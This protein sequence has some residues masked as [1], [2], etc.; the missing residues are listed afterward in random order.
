MS[1]ESSSIS[2]KWIVIATMIF[3]AFL[4]WGCAASFYSA[5]V[6]G[7][8]ANAPTGLAIRGGR[9]LSLLAIPYGIA[10]FC[11]VAVSQLPNLLA[12]SGYIF[13]HHIWLPITILVV[14]GL[15]VAGGF[16]LKKLEKELEVPSKRRYRR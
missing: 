10:T 12:V 16:G 3:V 5:N 1:D 11:Y 15:V 7:F 14:E 2:L 9:R 13:Q 8:H 4:G 6:E